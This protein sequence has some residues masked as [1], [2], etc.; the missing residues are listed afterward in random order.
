MAPLAMTSVSSAPRLIITGISKR[1]GPTIALD[2][3]NLAVQAGSCLALIGENGA[4]K[5]T[6][7]KVISG[8]HAPD[9]GTI[10][11]DGVAFAPTDPADA[12]RQGVAI[13]YQELTLAGHLSV[14]ENIVLGTTPSRFGFVAPRQRDA[15]ARSA[16]AL[17]GVNDLDPATPAGGLSVARQ[18]LVEIARAL[19]LGIP[20]L[21]VLDEPTASLTATDAARLF[22]AI[23]RLKAAGA[24]VLFISHH[25]EECRRVADR[26][27]VLRDGASVA[28]GVM[29][30][31][32]END[33]IRLMVGRE[34][35]ELFPHV[36]HKIGAPLLTV[37]H[38]AGRHL[39]SD[40]SFT[41]HAGEIFGIFGLVGS[42]RTEMLRCL[43]GL[44]AMKEGSLTL[45]QHPLVGT[46]PRARLDAG[47][48][49]VSEDRKGE[50]LAL[51]LSIADNLCLTRLQPFTAYGMIDRRQHHAA[52][53]TWMQ[54]LGVKAS[55]PAQVIGHLSGGNQQKVAIGR[56]LHHDANILLLDEPDPRHR[57]RRQS[58]GLPPDRRISRRGPGADTGFELPPRIARALRH[59]RGDA[60]W[61]AVVSAADGRARRPR[62]PY[63][64]PRPGDR[65]TANATSASWWKLS[66]TTLGPFFALILLWLGFALAVY[67]NAGPDDNPW[68]F[69]AWRN[70][71]LILV[72]SSII[73]IGACGIVMVIVAGGI[74]LSIG[75]VIALSSVI[76][77]MVLRAGGDPL[78][79]IAAAVGIGLAVG[80]GNG[81]I[82]AVTGITPFIVTLGTMGIARGMAKGF[83]DNQTVNLQPSWLDWIMRPFAAAADPWWLKLMP[84]APGVLL[85]AVVALAT[86]VLLRRSVFGRHLYAIGSNPAAARLCGIKVRAT[87]VAVYALSGALIGLAGILETAKL[88][89]GDPTTANGRELDV[90][91]AAVIGGASLAGGTGTALGAVLGA[92]IMGVLRNGSQLLDW[93]TWVQEIIIGVVIVVAVG[94]DRWRAHRA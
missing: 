56:L 73:S 59:H 12:R 93:P 38:L 80:A 15:I 81:F 69:M 54:R 25:L 61:S 14:A 87:T 48:G 18:Q 13:V 29:A 79:A 77:A 85:A 16:L 53:A 78:L 72:Q 94:I 37:N 10:Q 5:S 62:H 90:I 47:I 65:M 41:L 45:H 32:T 50:G 58:A 67:V 23:D 31:A 46:G 1:F 52:T 36:P 19:A 20:K 89:Q 40:A 21:L 76:G 57:R 92:L 70:Q 63:G 39:P 26:W 17:L 34:L 83:A 49:L 35:S 43:F 55:D 4:G 24:A 27:L 82:V 91:A 74:D 6:L 9:A 60:S 8:A 68:S 11:L 75:S 3:V 66:L 2:G 44:D 64:R 7:M 42:G 28:T 51:G 88:H 86:A 71:S 84:V 30:E 33:L 22:S